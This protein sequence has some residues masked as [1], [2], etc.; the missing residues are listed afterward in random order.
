MPK[1]YL[2]DENKNLVEGFDKEGFLALLEQAIEQ[3]SLENIDPNSAVASK[4]RSVLNGTTHNI[5]F[6]TQAQ[7]NELKAQG[8]LV[9]NTYYFITDDTTLEGLETTL[10][11]VLQ[12]LSTNEDNIS[13]IIDGRQ[14]VGKATEA[15]KTPFSLKGFTE[16][17]LPSNSHITLEN[18]E[19]GTYQFCLK[20]R[21]YSEG[22]VDFCNIVNFGLLLL[23]PIVPSDRLSY[24]NGFS[25]YS[26][27]D[28]LVGLSTDRNVLRLYYFSDLSNPNNLVVYVQQKDFERNDW[29]DFVPPSHSSGTN[30]EVSLLYKK[31]D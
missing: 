15:S 10:T 9:P 24:L 31:I 29:L 18:F 20:I 28:F 19:K 30:M 4:L 5:E 25:S 17:Q 26:E 22:S 6:V 14:V 11:E 7:Y 21:L 13:K 16:V 3:G 27:V 8:E 23:D 2:L 1:Y 12:R